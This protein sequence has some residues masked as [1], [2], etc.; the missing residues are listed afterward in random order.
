MYILHAVRHSIERLELE[1]TRKAAYPMQIGEQHNIHCLWMLPFGSRFIIYHKS[2]AG[3]RY[4]Y[5]NIFFLSNFIRR[6]IKL[7][8]RILN[9]IEMPLIVGNIF[10]ADILLTASR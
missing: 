2:L 1:K 8:L 4:E 7:C 6:Y 9:F 10:G 3:R 5:F